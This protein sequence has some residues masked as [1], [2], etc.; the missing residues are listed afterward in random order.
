MSHRAI[1]TDHAPAAIGPYSQA[2]AL[3]LGDRELLFLAGQIPLVPGTGELLDGAIEGQAEQVMQNLQAVLQEAGSDFGRVVKTTVFLRS[4]E[5]FA[6][7]N[8]VYGRYFGEVPPA[9]ATVA[10]RGLPKGVRIEIEAV[11]YR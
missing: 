4:M 9:R 3:S 8:E 10:V 6:A 2:I 7:V 1:H 11:A 5:D